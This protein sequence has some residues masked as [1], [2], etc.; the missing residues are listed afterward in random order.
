M[1]AWKWEVDG[2]CRWLTTSPGEDPWFN[3]NGGGEA[4]VYSGERF[5][6]EK[7]IPS[8]RLKLERN[9]IQDVAVL[10]IADAKIKAAACQGLAA[11]TGEVQRRGLV[12]P[13]A[14]VDPHAGRVPGTTP[15]WEGTVRPSVHRAQRS[16]IRTGG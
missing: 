1:Q 15:L 2:Y 6:L 7:P 3:F 11:A 16:S 5:G 4:M 8:I 9:V 12:E 10:K 13:D 14:R